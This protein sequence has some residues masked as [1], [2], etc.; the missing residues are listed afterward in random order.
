MNTATHHPLSTPAT[1]V[2]RADATRES[3]RPT[4]RTLEQCM[5]QQR[6]STAVVVPM[7][8]DEPMHPADR[9]VV[10]ACLLGAAA[11][12]VLVAIGAL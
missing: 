3:T 8:A 6:S 9:I 2:G 12:V 1:F 10:I 7:D 5:G 11:A 4:P